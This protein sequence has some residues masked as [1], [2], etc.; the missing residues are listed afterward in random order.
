MTQFVD[1]F[2]APY[3]SAQHRR[4]KVAIEDGL[5]HG[6]QITPRDP[7]PGQ[8]V[9]ISIF[10][11]AHKAIERVALSYTTDGTEPLGEYGIAT[12]GT[13][14]FA[15]LLP[16][17]SVGVDASTEIRTWQVTIPAQEDGTLVRYRIDGWSVQ[18]AGQH[19]YADRVDPVTI[20]Q[21]K[22]RSFAY[23]VDRWEAPAWWQ[24]AVVYQIFVDRF[25]SAHN[26]PALHSEETH[27][28]TEFFGGTLNG[29]LEKLD[30]IQSLGI[31]C[32]WLSPIFESPSHHGY[33]PSDYHHVA[34][35]YGSDEALVQL[36]E[37][38]HRRG[39][40][41]L[42][43]FVANHTSDEH[44][45]FVDARENPDSPYAN[46]Y[47]FKEIEA[48]QTYRSYAQVSSMPELST[49]EPAVREYLYGAARYWLEHYGADGL[50]L[51][52][53]PGPSHAFWT[54]F[55]QA[56]KSA[57]PQALTIGE[58]TSPMPE[59]L[60]YA[61]R[62]DGFMDFPLAAIMRQTFARRSKSLEELLQFL[63]QHVSNIPESMCF[64]AV[65]D[66][67]DMHRFLWFA[68]GNIERLKLATAFQM[69]LEGTP[70]VYYG[71]EVGLSQTDDAIK[72][73]AYCRGPMP[74]GEQQNQALLTYYRQLIALR[75]QHAVLRTG[76]RMNLSVESTGNVEQIGAY[77]R[78]INDTYMLVILNNNEQPVQVR[79]KLHNVLQKI[80]GTGNY[81]TGSLR[82]VFSSSKLSDLSLEDGCVEVTVPALSAEI[83]LSEK[84][85]DI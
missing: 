51:D 67:H 41:V 46:W 20:S 5:A 70:I 78:Y 35:R 14:L 80:G 59:I 13:V 47:D 66:N 49:E 36:I 42:L 33:N 55:Q 52:Y 61:G 15:E 34:R 21:K 22:G 2:F 79:I 38:A 1:F 11:N 28:I 45:A 10:S 40:R 27:G 3:A 71:T 76:K 32:I 64:A 17:V 84:R 48:P 18:E 68:E 37:A 30:Y 50:R 26:E 56:V 85:L 81:Q 31:N 69:T 16:Q 83:Y 65:L 39:I 9:T 58:V 44:F 63:D 73:N 6:S 19:W 72:E 74:W 60:D 25:S 43:D 53:V 4:M 29:I 54:S 24:D 23:H 77:I 62:M 8:A 75:R 57:H 12:Q 7:L 82:S